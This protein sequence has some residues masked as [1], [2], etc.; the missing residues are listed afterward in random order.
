[1]LSHVHIAPTHSTHPHLLDPIELDTGYTRVRVSTA[2]FV[3]SE[4]ETAITDIRFSSFIENEKKR[5]SSRRPAND[6]IPNVTID[7]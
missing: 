6:W 3:F 4:N 1:M 2:I 5:K 7:A